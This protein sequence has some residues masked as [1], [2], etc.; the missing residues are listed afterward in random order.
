M[1]FEGSREGV[2]SRGVLVPEFGTEEVGRRGFRGVDGVVR[3]A[4]M[5]D[6]MAIPIV[7]ADN[8]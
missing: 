2:S 5:P 7:P 1:N 6:R 8:C 3:E 4:R